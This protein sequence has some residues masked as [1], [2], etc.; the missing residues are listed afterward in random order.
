MYI[1]PKLW[2]KQKISI[3]IFLDPHQSINLRLYPGYNKFLSYKINVISGEIK[4]NPLLCFSFSFIGKFIVLICD[5]VLL[6][7]AVFVIFEYKLW[8]GTLANILTIRRRFSGDKVAT[9][10]HKVYNLSSKISWTIK[11]YCKKVVTGP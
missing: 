9:N 11:F 1:E 4:Y 5:V 7:K 2:S 3:E 8:I 6:L 10:K